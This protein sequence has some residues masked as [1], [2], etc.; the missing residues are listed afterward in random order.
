MIFTDED[1]KN[2]NNATHCHIC[3]GTHPKV[4]REVDHVANIEKWLKMMGLQ[5]YGQI[6]KMKCPEN[7][8][9]GKFMEAKM[10]I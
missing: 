5:R 4:D 7:V 9:E 2:F 6:E 8:D 1:K 3:E 10:N